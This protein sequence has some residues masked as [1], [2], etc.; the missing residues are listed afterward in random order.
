MHGMENVKIKLFMN[1][2]EGL[3]CGILGTLVKNIPA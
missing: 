2:T 1:Y 3:Q